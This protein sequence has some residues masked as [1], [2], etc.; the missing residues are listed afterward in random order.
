MARNT[1]AWTD[2][3]VQSLLR[4]YASEI[5]QDFQGCKRHLKIFGNISSQLAMLDIHHTPKQC[6]EKIKKLKQDYKKIKDH[7]EQNGSD[8]KSSKWFDLLDRILGHRSTYEDGTERKCIP[9]EHMQAI[10]S[11]RS[12]YEDNIEI[13]FTPAEHLQATASGSESNRTLTEACAEG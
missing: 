6:R 12:T 2:A 11:H 8:R 9:A 3:E 5:Q 7:N 13:K 1:R 4:I 10:A